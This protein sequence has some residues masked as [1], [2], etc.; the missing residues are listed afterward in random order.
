MTL[1][2]KK[3]IFIALIAGLTALTFWNVFSS[4][5]RNSKA[6]TLAA[7]VMNITMN[8]KVLLQSSS[9]QTVRVV[10]TPETTTDVVNQMNFVI[11][12]QGDSMIIDVSEPL[13]A[14]GSKISATEL[15]KFID[16]S[17][18]AA[19]LYYSFNSTPKPK[20]VIFDVL[21]MRKLQSNTC[22]IF[23]NMTSISGIIYGETY[24]S[25]NMYTWGT[26]ESAS[27][28]VQ[29]TPTPTLS[30][31]QTPTPTVAPSIAVSAV[32]TA[33]QL[34]DCQQLAQPQNL[35][36]GGVI[37]VTADGQKLS[38][39]PVPGASF[40][41]IEIWEGRQVPSQ[42]LVY[43][44]VFTTSTTNNYYVYTKFAQDKQYFWKVS[45][46]DKCNNA[47]SP[48]ESYITV[49]GTAPT[50][51]PQYPT[52]TPSVAIPQV[53]IKMRLRFQGIYTIPTRNPVSPQVFLVWIRNADRDNPI[54][55]WVTAKY[56]QTG[57][58]YIEDKWDLVPGDGY[59]VWIKG[60]KHLQ[61]QI[62][63]GK[64]S[65]QESGFY[66]CG[67]GNG[68]IVIRPG[69]NYLDFS[70][71]IMFAGDI[72]F[73]GESDGILDA[74]DLAYIATHFDDTAETIADLNFD[75]V[76]DSQDYGI[77]INAIRIQK[78]DE[79]YPYKIH[80][81]FRKVPLHPQFP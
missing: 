34:V 42:G 55:K 31:S 38:W 60:E 5:S 6:D 72:P 17:G 12:S 77:A 26:M 50:V 59:K 47:W 56:D 18:S 29:T 15:Y 36:P 8:P 21:V 35:S 13:N 33:V 25:S 81:F 14:D 51:T 61:R 80:P 57:S 58:W 64:P 28:T 1:M 74:F 66:K 41:G 65:D 46:V 23:I 40:Y 73:K 53:T 71:V 44:K 43:S 54:Y 9:P 7:H 32:P 76:T 79:T 62:C 69:E 39:D 24:S 52:A 2:K 48:N 4:Y 70:N 30:P 20:S 11:H 68:Q 19:N 45:A 49:L 75:G 3:H 10:F 78:Y 37:Y 27:C 22:S 63:D 16:F 67:D